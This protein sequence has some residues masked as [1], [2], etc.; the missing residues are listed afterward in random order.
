M[1]K[2][3]KSFIYWAMI[4]GKIVALELNDFLATYDSTDDFNIKHN[5]FH[6]LAYDIQKRH[7]NGKKDTLTK[8]PL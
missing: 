8:V 6:F 1:W 4:Y 5:T 2:E 3:A 7:C